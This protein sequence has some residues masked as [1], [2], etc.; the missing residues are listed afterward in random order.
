MRIVLMATGDIAI[1]SFHALKE[2][3]ELVALVTQPDRPVG[4]H[5]DL[6]PPPIKLHAVEAGIPVLQPESMRAPEAVAELAAMQ[7]DLLVVMAYGQILTEEVIALG[8]M[9]CINAHASLLPRHRGAACIQAAIDAGDS[10]TGVTIMH[11]VKRL[12]AGDI[13]THRRIPLRGTETAEDLQNTL[14]AITPEALLEVINQLRDGTAPREPQ[15]EQLSTYAP[16]L[17]RKDGFIDWKQ[18]DYIIAR[19]IRA[20]HSW[21]G[22]Y[23][24]YPSVRRDRKKNLKIFPPVDLIPI[25]DLP[26]N[27]VPGE[28]LESNGCGLIVA[29]GKGAIRIS[30][31]Q[32]EGGRR[33]S[34]ESFFSGHA[35]YPGAILGK[36]L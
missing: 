29:C 20:Y 12:D 28:V 22:T 13:I 17:L 14:A 30:T 16:K 31:L 27:T 10:E 11:V 2:S 24:D 15:D 9:G 6:T 3:G 19:K 4:R 18:P 1:P 32:P 7:P 33:M 25:S 34:A 21:P 26:A 5:Q 23:T 36:A 8:C 35:L